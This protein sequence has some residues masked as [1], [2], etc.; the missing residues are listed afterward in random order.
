MIKHGYSKFKLDILEFCDPSD[1]IA[2]EQ[3]YI[4][5][6][7]PDYN[8]LQVA[9]SLFGYKHTEESLAKMKEIA[10]NRS[11][12]TKAKLREA[13]LGKPHIHT[14]ETKIKLRDA[15]L[16]KKHTEETRKNLRGIQANRIKQPVAG[17]KIEV[18]DTQTGEISFYDSLRL[19]A[20][21]LNSNHT[22]ISNY[23]K[24]GKLLRGR[25]Q[26]T[27]CPS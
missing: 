9:G 14:E 10:L 20:I 25:Y 16:G 17:V 13:A 7:K 18:N 21:G 26:L 27:K 11:D 8:I 3:S 6:L 5:N 4:D 2:K 15:M 19:A 23:I 12:E 22:N 1:V 24:N